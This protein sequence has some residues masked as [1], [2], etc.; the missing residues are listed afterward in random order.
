MSA[1]RVVVLDTP[2]GFLASDEPHA[3]AYRETLQ[4]PF[5]I[6]PASADVEGSRGTEGH[7]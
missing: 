2:E 4:T 1:G 7:A 3:R 6:P 5:E